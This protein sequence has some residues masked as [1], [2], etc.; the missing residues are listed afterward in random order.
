MI[1]LEHGGSVYFFVS[2]HMSSCVDIL[3][4][5]CLKKVVTCESSLCSYS[6]NPSSLE[7]FSRNGME[8]VFTESLFVVVLR[9]CWKFKKQQVT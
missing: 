1:Y 5:T 7:A 4:K 3:N 6:L 8:Q 2:K 9:E